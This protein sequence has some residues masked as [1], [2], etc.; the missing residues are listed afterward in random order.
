MQA[1]GH[2]RAFQ[3]LAGAVLLSQGHETGHFGLGDRDFFS[4][5]IG[6]RNI[7]DH[8]VLIGLGLYHSAHGVFSMFTERRWSRIDAVK[9]EPGGTIPVATLLGDV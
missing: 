8:E 2:A 3:R 7:G 9:S 1:A 4:T 5:E 6:Q